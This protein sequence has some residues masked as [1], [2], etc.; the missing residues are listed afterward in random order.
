MSDI[1]ICP[2]VKAKE[3]MSDD[4]YFKALVAEVFQVVI[5]IEPVIA[6]WRYIERAFDGF[7]VDKVAKFNN[8]DIERLML[9]ARIIRNR[10]KIR[11]VIQNAREF[12]KIKSEYG[13]FESYI[14]SFEGDTKRLVADLDS[15]LHYVGAPSIR[16]FLSCVTQKAA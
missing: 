9:D 14:K 15:R 13:S 3:H 1:K 4:E 6:R 16:R 10:K 8:A 12:L 5:G 7:S 2:F 11:A